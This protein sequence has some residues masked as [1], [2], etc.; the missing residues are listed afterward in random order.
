MKVSSISSN[1]LSSNV[2]ET[3]T[4]SENVNFKSYQSVFNETIRQKINNKNLVGDVLVKMVEELKSSSN[5]INSDFI[6]ALKS[7]IQQNKLNIEEFLFR[8]TSRHAGITTV[9]K[10]A[11]NKEVAYVEKKKLTFLDENS[12]RSITFALG[13]NNK[14]NFS[15]N[16]GFWTDINKFHDNGVIKSRK[17]IHGSGFMDSIKLTTRY[18]QKGEE[19]DFLSFLDLF[20]R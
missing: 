9:I 16:G 15:R 20:K 2:P 13:K 4:V 17:E 14:L 19:L 10:N 3:K 5:N 6:G 11:E 7:S 8:V 1:L 18:N 12:N